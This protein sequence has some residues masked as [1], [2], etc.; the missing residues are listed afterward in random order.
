LVL[1][2][3]DDFVRVL[4]VEPAIA[5]PFIRDQQRHLVGNDLAD[6][7]FEGFGIDAFDDAGDDLTPAL[8]SAAEVA[9]LADPLQWDVP[10]PTVRHPWDDPCR[11]CPK[12][13]FVVSPMLSLHADTLRA[14]RRHYY[15]K[16]M[17]QNWSA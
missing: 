10:E 3:A 17:N 16:H 2:V 7:A 8:D 9:R 14:Y 13:E 15:L 6:E 1:G 11:G 12:C 5:D 4:F